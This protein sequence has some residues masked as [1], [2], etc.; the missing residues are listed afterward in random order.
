M[1]KPL[2]LIIIFIFLSSNIPAYGYTQYGYNQVPAYLCEIGIEYYNQGNYQEALHEF[3]KALLAQ[4]NYPLAL[5]YIKKIT[6]EGAPKLEE[7]IAP[8]PKTT[9]KKRVTAIN[10]LLDQFETLPTAVPQAP[11]AAAKAELPK[12]A[13]VKE[14][15]PK[16]TPPKEVLFPQILELN[17]NIKSLTAPI[18]IEQG[19]SL[20]IAGKN[21]TRF[22]VI[23]PGVISVEK[24]YSDELLLNGKEIGF[25]YL[26]IWDNNGRWT[27]QFLTIPAKP[28]GPTL[29]EIMR[30][31]EE[32]AG[33]FKLRYS[34]SYDLFEKGRRAYSLARQSYSYN[35]IL[36]L[37]GQTPF[38]NLSSNLG[39]RSS[40]IT[41]DLSY[42]TLGLTEGRF[43][44]FKDFTL[45][46]LDYTPAF[47]NLTFNTAYL[48]GIMLESSAFN[49]KI[50][51]TIFWGREGGG[52]YGNLSPGLGKIKD[53]FLSGMDF[54]YRPFL[55]QDYGFS[56]IH[57]WG[58]DRP[59]NLHPY[60]Y[61]LYADTK[62]SDKQ[63]LRYEIAND[64]QK[65]AHLFTSTYSVPK[66]HLT[67]E[68]RNID[69]AFQ[70]AIGNGYRQ[71][72]LGTLFNLFITPSEKLNITSRL[73][74]YQDR[75]FPNSKSPDIWNE[76]FDWNANYTINPATS[77]VL[78]YT[79][80]NDLG[81]LG[82]FRYYSPAIGLSRTLE[83]LSKKIYTF[84]NFRYQK[85]QDLTN[86]T[87]DYT[88]EKVLLGLRIPILGSLN[89]YANQEFNWLHE[90][91]TDN[92]TRPQAFETGVDWTNQIL[93]TPFYGDFRLIYR[94]ERNTDSSLS[95]LSGEDY[96][97]GYAQLS[98]RPNPETELFTS[99]RV[100]NVWAGGNQNVEKRV[101]AEFQS[102]MRYTWDTGLRWESIGTIDGYVFK[103]FNGNGLRDRDDPP[104]EG[105]K[106]WLGKDKSTVTDIFGY[107][108]FT[109]VKAKNVFLN[110]D[111][112]AIPS[113]FMLTVPALQEVSVLHGQTARVYFGIVS[114]SEITGTIFEDVD[115]DGQ[116]GLRDKGIGSVVLTLEDGKKVITDSSGRYFLRNISIGKHTITLDLKSLPAQYIPSVPIFK[117]IELSEGMSF[118]YNI[119][120]KKTE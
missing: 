25:T 116:L 120:V 117:D 10:E 65:F 18:E 23:S 54:N 75:L 79:L 81:R 74:V 12:K 56:V 109:K 67:T 38:G 1:K 28:E 46:A 77:L 14:L 52:R 61:D 88:N 119:P 49:K 80:Q 92:N 90:I 37:D 114:R 51:Y 76:D 106:I 8:L 7:E 69:K 34:L 98:Y 82:P 68:I 5:E 63:K 21:I 94:E 3:N 93:N 4:P 102:G 16:E 27:L 89:Y 99:G 86:P 59:T 17:E 83:I 91:S 111:I 66:F 103:D 110:I 70:T 107:F 115:A 43:G 53:S 35:H 112:S 57:G 39:V 11:K 62:V 113:G 85:N 6:K 73:D 58:T 15:L 30:Q 48:R 40:S 104:V 78:N 47:N 60:N 100:R 24:K 36:S 71:G 26:H 45:R 84:T 31:A 20:I 64:S 33:T 101:E 42:I 96:L 13:L 72:Q 50:D 97:E 105:I 29:E 9:P 32:H 118:V 2:A 19:K 44:Q 22:L 41:T 87:V 95:F 108:R 55:K